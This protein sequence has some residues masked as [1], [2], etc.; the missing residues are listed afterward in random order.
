MSITKLNRDLPAIIFLILAMCV[1]MELYFT[2]RFPQSIINFVCAVV[3]FPY[4]LKVKVLRQ[5]MLVVFLL[6]VNFIYNYTHNTVSFSFLSFLNLGS[7]IIIS[8]FIILSSV[9][10]KIKLLRGFDLF[11]K[12]ICC[13]SLVGWCF[14]LIGIPL[15]HYYS[16][17]SDFYTH[18]VYYLFIA[19][20]N[21]ILEELLPR[22]CG[23]FLEP[24]HV[25]STSCLLLFIN[26]FNFKNKSNFI[27]LLSIIFSL[28]LA[29]Y[30]LLFIGLC[31]HFFLKGV[32]IVKYILFMGAFAG[33]FYVF[34]LTYNGGDNILNEKI[35]SRLVVVDG[36]LSGDNRTSML[37]DAYYED[38][39]K[40]GDVINGYGKKAYGEGSEATNI[41]HGCA[42]FKRFFFI[43]GIIGVMLVAVL[44]W[45]LFYKFRSSQGW[46]FFIL[47]VI[48]NMIRDYPFRLMWLYLFILGSVV[49]SLPEKRGHN[50]LD[51]YTKL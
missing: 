44:Y 32:H 6:V 21:N 40:H 43:N 47:F 18:E 38:W 25:G 7:I 42:S 33:I 35:L 17:T 46:G 15:P 37:F 36:E 30:C 19:G 49:L 4:L 5:S 2:W 10:F 39:L 34:G 41:L 8:I 9:D 14:Y 11:M 51:A 24:G 27:Y 28:S 29:A 22:F 3:V 12:C 26:K 50:V 45:S 16:E 23:M 48:C 1:S 31:L 13:I 20:A